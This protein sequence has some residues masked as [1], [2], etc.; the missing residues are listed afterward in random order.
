M[1]DIDVRNHTALAH[2]HA[3]ANSNYALTDLD[4]QARTARTEAR[5]AKGALRVLLE[6]ITS[7]PR[8]DSSG[9]LAT[10]RPDN[11]LFT[12]DG[13]VSVPAVAEYL[14]RVEGGEND[15]IEVLEDMN[16]ERL[17]ADRREPAIAAQRELAR[18]AYS[19]P[20]PAQRHPQPAPQLP[21]AKAPVPLPQRLVPPAPPE[22]PAES[23]GHLVAV[24]EEANAAGRISGGTLKSLH[25]AGYGEAEEPGPDFG[26]AHDPKFAASAIP[27]GR[28]LQDTATMRADEVLAELGA[29]DASQPGNDQ[30]EPRPFPQEATERRSAAASG[31]DAADDDQ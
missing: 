16:S 25:E 27:A 13:Q 31:R 29:A 28:T 9:L 22:T 24:V 15:P 11:V 5:H 26:P 17:H 30:P 7:K 23:T 20:V 8:L 6:Q 14:E 4:S 2:S 19:A 12:R 1:N 3:V 21:P 18:L 10:A